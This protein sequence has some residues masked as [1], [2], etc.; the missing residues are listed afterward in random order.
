MRIGNIFLFLISMLSILNAENNVTKQF[1]STEKEWGIGLVIRTATIPYINS[2]YSKDSTVSSFIPSLY[3]QGENF[4]MNGTE[5]GYRLYQTPQWSASVFTRLR[6]ADLPFELQNDIQEDSYDP[7]LQFRYMF[8]KDHNLDLEFMSDYDKNYYVNLAYEKK[9]DLG[10][11]EIKPYV[12]GTYHSA[13]FNS[14]YYGLN[15]KELNG[16]VE[17]AAGAHMRYHV[18]SNFYLLANVQ[19]KFLSNSASSSEYVK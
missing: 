16:G 10:D 2:E 1:I 11:F 18:V 3:Y 5:L 7:G 15:Q 14:K 6:F 9:F 17:V 19:T 12:I 4:Y 13:D 8:E